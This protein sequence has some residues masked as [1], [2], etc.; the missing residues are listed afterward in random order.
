MATRRAL[1]LFLFALSVALPLS[2]AAQTGQLSGT[3][4]VEYRLVHKF[5]TITGT[6]KAMVV[7]GSVDASGLKLMARA[8]VGTFDSGNS[9]RDAHMMEAVEG[10]KFPWV[11]VRAVESSFKLPTGKGTTKVTLQASV[12]LHGVAVSHPIEVTLETKD[13]QHF[14][15]S[16]TFRES[17]TAHKIERPSLLFVPVD[18]LITIAGQAEI[19]SK[20]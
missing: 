13:G 8:Q 19:A 4:S 2:G 3:G 16:F 17:L 14:Q 6:S 10:E 20:S 15:A 5:H 12:E 7:R 11:N 18:D 9:N 1:S